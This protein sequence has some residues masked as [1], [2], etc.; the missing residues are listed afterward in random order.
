MN[1][2]ENQKARTTQN[3]QIAAYLQAGHSIT[4]LEALELFGCFRLASRISDLRKRNY[5]ITVKRVLTANGKK[6]A[7][8]SLNQ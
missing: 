3:A 2:N 4:A 8:Y 5:N 1:I 7:Q 6:I